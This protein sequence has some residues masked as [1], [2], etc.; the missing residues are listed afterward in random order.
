MLKDSYKQELFAGRADYLDRIVNWAGKVDLGEYR[1]F[2]VVG[3]PGCGKSWVLGRAG[4]LLELK[5]KGHLV[6]RL[7]LSLDPATGA[8]KNDVTVDARLRDWLRRWLISLAGSATIPFDPIPIWTFWMPTSVHW[9]RMSAKI[10]GQI[11]RPSSWW[12]GWKKYPLPNKTQ[13]SARF[14]AYSGGT[15]VFASCWPSVIRMPS[16]TICGT[17][18]VFIA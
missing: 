12:M 6:F 1:I 3:P 13:Y 7:D 9:P 4:E 8:S 5:G 2:S 15:I 17:M 16:S 11:A 14:W 18:K 10:V